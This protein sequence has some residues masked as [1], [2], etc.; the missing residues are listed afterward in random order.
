MLT[1]FSIA[2]RRAQGASRRPGYGGSGI[3]EGI[4][5]YGKIPVYTGIYPGPFSHTGYFA[6]GRPSSSRR[7]RRGCRGS[8]ATS[9]ATPRA[10]R[11]RARVLEFAPL[12]A[13]RLKAGARD[14]PPFLISGKAPVRAALGP[15]RRAVALGDR[16][17]VGVLHKY[18]YIP[19][20]YHTDGIYRYIPVPLCP[21][22][23]FRPPYAKPSPAVCPQ[24]RDSIE[25]SRV[26]VGTP[27]DLRRRPPP[28][29][30]APAPR[31]PTCP[32]LLFKTSGKTV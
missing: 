23:V 2:S 16:R 12:G 24:H 5:R 17:G 20:I 13:T 14:A 25:A 32:V 31:L 27:E 8:A 28:R 19:G 18:R 15:A 3:S 22:R 26:D 11:A 10:T 4:Y 9:R 1:C 7:V 6:F 30:R 29:R 21:Y